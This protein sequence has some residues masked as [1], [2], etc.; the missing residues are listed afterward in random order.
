V[1][2]SESSAVLAKTQQHVQF[3][4]SVHMQQCLLFIR[5]SRICASDYI[6]QHHIT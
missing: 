2:T 6:L 3:R 1:N 4:Q 5:F